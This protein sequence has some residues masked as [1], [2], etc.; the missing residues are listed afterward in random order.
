[1]GGAQALCGKPVNMRQVGNGETSRI[2]VTSQ[3]NRDSRSWFISS[4]GGKGPLYEVIAKNGR[5]KPDREI[6]ITRKFG[7]DVITQ[8]SESTTLFQN[9][10]PGL[11]SHEFEF[12]ADALQNELSR[13]GDSN[14]LASTDSNVRGLACISRVREYG[15]RHT[16]VID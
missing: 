13:G 2:V 10:K 9:G 7:Q 16:G 5:E 8:T 12:V 3:A 15:D 14:T 11:T 6:V 1:M 4:S